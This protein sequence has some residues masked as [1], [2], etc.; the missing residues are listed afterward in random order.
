MKLTVT[1]FVSLDGVMQAPG[2]PHEDESGG[3]TQGG[4]VVPFVDD[5]FG[6]FITGVF[7]RPA[8][9]LLGRGTYQIFASWWPKVTDPADPVAAALNR[10]P[11]YVASR[12]LARADWGPATL[13]RDVVP[14]VERLRREG[15]GE[16][17]VHGSPGLLQT[18]LRQGLVDELNLLEFPV[19]LGG[20]KRLF[21]EGAVPRAFQTVAA[22]T[23][24]KGVVLRTL[25]PD[26]APVLGSVGEPSP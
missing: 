5:E 8:A 16:L 12:T 3:F 17:Q 22:R 25:R 9:F 4:W 21:G 14:A 10:L 15:E 11:K 26:G 23:S 7:A 6:A 20:G 13:V 19:V 1:S 2:G 18:L 24:S